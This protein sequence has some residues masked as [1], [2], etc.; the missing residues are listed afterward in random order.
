MKR[1]HRFII[2]C[3]SILIYTTTLA[4]TN[5]SPSVKLHSIAKVSGEQI[6]NKSDTSFNIVS[7]ADHTSGYEIS[8][9]NKVVIRQ[10]TIPGQSGIKGFKSRSDAEKVARLVIKK[11]SLG[12]MPPTI[13]DNELSKLKIKY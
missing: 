7:T 3:F 2:S 5:S 4:Q 12:I 13:D 11:L 10:L 6:I 1:L 9:R 8:I